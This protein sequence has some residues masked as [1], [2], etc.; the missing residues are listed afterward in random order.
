MACVGEGSVGVFGAG[1]RGGGTN[2][3]RPSDRLQTI[4]V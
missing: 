1:D 3:D 2:S 4:N